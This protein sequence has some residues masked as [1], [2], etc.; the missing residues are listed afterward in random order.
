MGPNLYIDLLTPFHNLLFTE[1]DTLT[2][3]HLASRNVFHSP[4]SNPRLFLRI[5]LICRM[6]LPLHDDSELI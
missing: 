6:S 2:P 4:L 5:R 3:Y 1:V